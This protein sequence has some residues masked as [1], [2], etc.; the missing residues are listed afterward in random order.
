MINGI[1]IP[2]P[3]SEMSEWISRCSLW[4]LPKNEVKKALTFRWLV[5]LTKSYDKT[6]IVRS[7]KSGV[8][9]II[10]FHDVEYNF[11]NKT[12]YGSEISGKSIKKWFDDDI[13][14][15]AREMVSKYNFQELRTIVDE[16]V[17]RIDRNYNQWSISIC[18]RFGDLLIKKW[19]NY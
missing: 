7:Y 1:E 9:N 17:N 3:P 12:H 14:D 2:M 11:T 13:D 18:T 4:S 10:P 6:I 8:I 5:G 19:Y 16:V 15:V